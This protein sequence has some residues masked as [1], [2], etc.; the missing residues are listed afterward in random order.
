MAEHA[1]WTFQ[2]NGGRPFN[3]SVPHNPALEHEGGRTIWKLVGSQAL[4]DQV[5]KDIADFG[6]TVKRYTE[7]QTP[8]LIEARLKIPD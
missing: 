3:L 6:G 8:E 4:A 1:V 2:I 7:V 5:E